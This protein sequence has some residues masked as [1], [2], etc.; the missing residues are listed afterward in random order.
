[1]EMGVQYGIYDISCGG[2]SDLYRPEIERSGGA[3]MSTSFLPE[4][5]VCIEVADSDALAVKEPIDY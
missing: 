4:S 1:M 3:L 5:I 2:I